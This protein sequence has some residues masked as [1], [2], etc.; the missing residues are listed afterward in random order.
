MVQNPLSKVQ[1]PCGFGMS[2]LKWFYFS[3]K[4]GVNGFWRKSA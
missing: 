4:E 1:A 3:E 2:K